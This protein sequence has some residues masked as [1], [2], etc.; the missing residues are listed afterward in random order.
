MIVLE[1]AWLGVSV[2]VTGT[3]QFFLIRS[4]LLLLSI[5]AGLLRLEASSHCLVQ[6]GDLFLFLKMFRVARVV[7]DV[8]GEGQIGL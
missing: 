2:V 8:M 4:L 1:H 7:N 6:L 5:Q 3:R